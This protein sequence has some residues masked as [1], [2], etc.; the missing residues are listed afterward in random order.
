MP[1]NLKESVAG[2]SV[3]SRSQFSFEDGEEDIGMGE[4]Y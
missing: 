2:L 1:T 4:G 3:T